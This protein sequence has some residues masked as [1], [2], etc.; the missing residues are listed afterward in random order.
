MIGPRDR[1]PPYKGYWYPHSSNGWGIFDFLDLCEAAG[2][3]PVVDLN[4]D[5]TPQDLADFVEYAN[6]PAGS[7]W[8]R[9]RA[10]DGHP[11][12]APR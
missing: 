2:F 6:G 5:E 4:M 12:G 11:Q 3:L 1:R 8:G 9:R 10:R 7:E